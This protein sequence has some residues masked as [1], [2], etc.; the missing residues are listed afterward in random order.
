MIALIPTATALIGGNLIAYQSMEIESLCLFSSY[1]FLGPWWHCYN[2]YLVHNEGRELMVIVLVTS[3]LGLALWFMLMWLLGPIG[4]YVGFLSQMLLRAVA[5]VIA[6][7][8]KW[9]ITIAWDGVAAGV[10]L[11]LGGFAVGAA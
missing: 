9:P 1:V 3:A 7:R 8:R 5:I 10:L 4:I 2:Y 6:A 11:V